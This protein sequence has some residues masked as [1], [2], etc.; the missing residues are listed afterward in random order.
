V[1]VDKSR[2]AQTLARGLQLLDCFVKRDGEIGTKEL[3]EMLKLPTTIVVRLAQTLVEFGYLNQDPTTRKYT[4]GLAAYT[5]GLHASPNL[6]LRRLALPFMEEIAAVTRETVSLNVV[7]PVRLEGVCIASIDSPNQIKLTTRVG[8]VR[9]LHRGASRKVL[10]AYLEDVEREIVLHRL[11]ANGATGEEMR[12]LEQDVIVIRNQA[13]AYS[14][15]EL[16][17]GAYAVAAPILHQ[18]KLV[19]SL[20]VAGPIYRRTET[21]LADAISI[22]QRCSETLSNIVRP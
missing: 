19:G 11:E 3:V 5:L 21:T 7:E 20:A 8:S 18:G 1:S 10:L 13:Y 17:E 9:P 4:M 22:I 12:Q 15:E 16:D 6:Q 2:T 14:E